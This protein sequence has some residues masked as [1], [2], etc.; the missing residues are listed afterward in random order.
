MSDVMNT[1][2]LVFGTL[3]V[4]KKIAEMEIPHYVRTVVLTVI[5][6]CFVLY[7]GLAFSASSYFDC[8]FH[9]CVF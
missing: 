6:T 3:L 5:I 8:A 9:D 2:A 1:M 4:L 7:L